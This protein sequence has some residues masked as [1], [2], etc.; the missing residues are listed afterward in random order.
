MGDKV[1][2]DK[3]DIHSLIHPWDE[4]FCALLVPRFT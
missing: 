2:V 4:G 1:V 3:F